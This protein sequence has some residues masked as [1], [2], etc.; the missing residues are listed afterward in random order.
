MVYELENFQEQLTDNP[1]ETGLNGKEY[2]GS[3][4]RKTR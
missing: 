2:I 4:S 1:T 3:F